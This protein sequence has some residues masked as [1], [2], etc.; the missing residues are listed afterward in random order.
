MFGFGNAYKKRK[1]E[2]EDRIFEINKRAYERQ[3]RKQYF[4]PNG[5]RRRIITSK[6]VR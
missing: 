6:K 3:A 2:Y 5:Q 1:A 4:W